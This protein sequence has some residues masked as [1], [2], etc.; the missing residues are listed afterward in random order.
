[1]DKRI[2]KKIAKEWCK[3]ILLAN[4]L[5]AFDDKLDEILTPEEQQFIVEE[6]HKIPKRITSEPYSSSLEQ[7]VGKYYDFE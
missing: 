6:S 4:E 2:L 3:G 5:D 7:I 1:M